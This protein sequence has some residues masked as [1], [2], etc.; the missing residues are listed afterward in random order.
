MA[1]RV[2][3]LA[4]RPEGFR[5]EGAKPFTNLVPLTEMLGEVLGV[6]ASSGRVRTAYHKLLAHAGSELHVLTEWPV[7]DAER[8]GPPLFG[9]ALR[10]MRAGEVKRIAGFDGEYGIV[11]VFDDEERKRLLA[12]TN[13]AFA[14]AEPKRQPT[15]AKLPG[16]PKRSA[17]KEVPAGP[18]GADA[19]QAV[20][21]AHGLGPMLVVA[22]PGA[23]KTRTLV[24][25]MARL[26]GQDGVEPAT[27]TAI[28]FTRKA[29]GELRERLLA[30]VG[31][32][33]EAVSAMTFHAFGLS[34]LR[35]HATAAGLPTG[36]RVLD[37]AGRQALVKQVAERRGLD[38]EAGKLASAI[39]R[40]KADGQEAELPAEVARVLADYERAL[41]EE[42][43]LDFDDL[44]VRAVRL[45]EESPQAL[46]AARRRCQH[47]LVDEYQDINR[48]QYRLVRLLARSE[49]PGSLCVVGDPDQAIYGF[50]GSDPAY[51]A[52][53]IEDYP[54]GR[55]VSLARNYRSTATVVYLAQAVIDRAPGRLNRPT[56]AVGTQGPQVVRHI[57]AD[58]RAEADWIAAEIER[59]V[60]GTQLLSSGAHRAAEGDPCDLAFHDIAVLTRLSAQGDAIEEALGRASIPCRRAGDDALTARPHVADLLARLQR[61]VERKGGA[62]L[63]DAIAGLDP[64]AV[65]DPRRQRAVELLCT[66][67]LPFASD[68]GAFLEAIA[69]WRES[70]LTQAP[71]KVSLLTMHA[72]K[73]LEFPLVFIAGCEDAILP[74]RLPWLPPANVDEERRLLYVGMTRAKQRLVL[75]AARRRNLLGR[76]VENRA[77]P[78]LDELPPGLL[79]DEQV[80]ERR[81]RP[82]QLSLI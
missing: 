24:E 20:V 40:A 49:G 28:T 77:C 41:A 60:G 15:T 34:L 11:R 5:P 26:I 55:M 9:E 36:F 45:L 76:A 16:T 58:E 67:A 31:P 3:A 59:A 51:F 52:R 32:R 43:A 81:R 57:V 63:A 7:E 25:R 68:L 4:D 2:A 33:A 69:L 74:L 6:G 35:E 79:L 71:Q 12:Q 73:G 23:G 75:V 19:D 80:A 10:R 65:L 44:V 53:F 37:E 78:F 29:A 62:L 46:V 54:A 1:S 56:T 48:S 21:I 8:E 22:G 82:R 42:R 50:R 64:D 30:A 72:S 27:I 47:L 61:T 66:L 18:T 14:G 39:S 70:D 17:K 13:F 38:G